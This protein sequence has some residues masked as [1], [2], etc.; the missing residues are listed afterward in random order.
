MILICTNNHLNENYHI[1][2][3]AKFENEVVTL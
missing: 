2:E 3:F 1:N